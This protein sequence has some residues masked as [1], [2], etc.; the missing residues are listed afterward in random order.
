[1]AELPRC[2]RRRLGL[3]ED[4]WSGLVVGANAVTRTR[5]GGTGRPSLERESFGAPEIV[6]LEESSDESWT[7]T[8]D[9]ASSESETCSTTSSTTDETV[10]KP[11][12]TRVILEVAHLKKAFAN[13][14]CPKCMEP[15]EF[16]VRTVCI[17]SNIELICNNNECSYVCDFERPCPTTIHVDERCNYERMTDYAINVLYVLGFIS[18]GDGPTE[19]GRILGLM[20]L[21]N[22]TTM[23]NRSFGIIEGRVGRFVRELCEEIISRNIEEEAKLSMNEFDYNVWKMWSTN[24]DLGPIPNDRMPQIDASYDMAWQQKGSGHQYNSQSGHGSLFGRYSRKIIGLVIKSKLCYYC[25]GYKKK[26]P[27]LEVPEHHCWMNHEDGSSGS[28]ESSGAVQ[29]LVECYEKCKVVIKRLCCDDDSSIRAD[30]QWSNADY[31]KN[32]NTDVLPMV[33]K[34][35]GKNKGE[36]VPRPD[37]GKLPSHVPEP[38]FVADPNHRRKGLT[39]E[40]IKLDTSKVTERFTMT[41]M[42]STR[43]GKNFGYMARTLK[44]RDEAEYC[45]AAQACL[46][47]HFDCHQYCGDWCKRK[48]ESDESKKTSVKYYRCKKKDAKLYAV[49]SEKMER[50]CTQERLNEMAHTLDTNMNEAFNQI[51]TWFAPKN[52]VFAGSGS[53]TNRISFAVGINSLGSEAFFKR[54]FKSLGIPLTNNV[55]YYLNTKEKTRVKR[56]AKVKTKE[57][58][59]I[60][61]KRKYDKLADNVKIAKKEL[62]KRQGTYRRGMNLDDPVGDVDNSAKPPAAKKSKSTSARFCEYCGTKGHSTT[63]SGKCTAKGSVVKRFNTDTGTLLVASD[64]RLPMGTALEPVALN[65]EGL[66]AQRD[67]D[68]MDSLPFDTEYESEPELLAA[69]LLEDYDSD[70]DGMQVQ[71]QVVGII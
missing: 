42:D 38:L 19:A 62:H 59:L 37:K 30:C 65:A 36:L 25:K 4:N 8:A 11:S 7:P 18:V 44:D 12:P 5:G 33:P 31:L 41:R 21:P 53:L 63:R 27:D 40:L 34:S 61:N 6:V 47:H 51:C 35:K 22:D 32:N 1:M 60:K 46:E 24:P 69:M 13:Y 43:I 57:A 56:L 45:K 52:K 71:Q 20:G 48:N 14:P 70:D 54:L 16:K 39:G 67:C 15:L 29:C 10:Q 26:H 58:K 50:F 64:T 49:L 68:L 9:D 17:A 66:L 2:E 55:A 23:M 3:E 28:M